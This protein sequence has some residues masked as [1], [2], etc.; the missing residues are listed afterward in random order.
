LRDRGKA[1]ADAV[2]DGKDE[3]AHELVNFVP[4]LSQEEKSKHARGGDAPPGDDA[5][6][7]GE[8]EEKPPAEPAPSPLHKVK[9]LEK[10]GRCRWGG[11]RDLDIEDLHWASPTR[12]T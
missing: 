12:R 10:A 7:N 1:I 3:F 6:E 9:R 11:I 4:A 2:R 8:K 5:T